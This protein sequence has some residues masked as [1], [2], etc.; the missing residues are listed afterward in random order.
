MG[1]LTPRQI[2][3]LKRN[4][5][6]CNAYTMLRNKYPKSSNYRIINI[7]CEHYDVC[8]STVRLILINGLGNEYEKHNKH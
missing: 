3:R 1:E 8:D 5:R 4:K 2:K 6:I 7:L